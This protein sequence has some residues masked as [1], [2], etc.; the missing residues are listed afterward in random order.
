MGLSF[1]VI[2]GSIGFLN[3][4]AVSMNLPCSTATLITHSEVEACYAS[5]PLPS[6]QRLNGREDTTDAPHDSSPQKRDRGPARRA[7][8]PRVRIAAGVAG[9][10]H[11]EVSPALDRGAE[12]WTRPVAGTPR[13]AGGC[14]AK[15]RRAGQRG[16]PS[17]CPTG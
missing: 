14:A 7:A 10:A 12:G 15:G 1:R 9:E 4:F 13:V 3:L 17:T 11:R 8:R 2:T 16:G 6:C 5:D